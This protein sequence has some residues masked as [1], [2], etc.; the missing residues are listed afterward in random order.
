MKRFGVFLIVLTFSSTLASA[1][2]AAESQ[3]VKTGITGRLIY[4][5]D[6]QGDRILDFSNVGYKG[7]GS[8][9]ITE[10]H[11]DGPYRFANRRRRHR[12]YPGGDQR[13]GSHALTGQRIPRRR[14]AQC[15]RLRHRHESQHQH[16]RH[17]PARRGARNYRYRPAWPRNHPAVAHSDHRV[18]LA[19]GDRLGL[20][21]DRQSY[22]GR[23]HELS[24][25]LDGRPGRGTN[26]ARR[27]SR[28]PSLGQCDRNERPA[29]HR[30]RV[31]P[32]RIQS[33]VR[34]RHHP[35]RGQSRVRRR[36]AGDVVRRAIRRRYFATLQLEWPDS[37]CRHRERAG[38]IRFQPG[39]G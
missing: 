19:S 29:R 16:Q 21:D 28:H 24:S 17:C 6:A 23:L 36:P 3:W 12:E 1:A 13:G 25:Q 33:A 38:R 35:H 5:P 9:L 10:R 2:A 4:V 8:A 7:R 27:A 18:W 30:S 14:A 26:G 20:L 37:K 11:P 32:Q 22:P 31:G 15:G 34:S 39:G